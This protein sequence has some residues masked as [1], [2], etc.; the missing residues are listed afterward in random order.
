MSFL[1][2]NVPSNVNTFS[3]ST[4]VESGGVFTVQ[5]IGVPGHDDAAGASCKISGTVGAP[6]VL[7]WHTPE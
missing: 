3:S 4:V 6:Q 7:D 2:G 1:Y 5:T